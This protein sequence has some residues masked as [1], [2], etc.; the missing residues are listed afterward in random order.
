MPKK[1]G[2]RGKDAPQLDITEILTQ[3][4]KIRRNGK[5][6]IV[7]QYEL[8]LR[9]QVKK[10]LKDKSLPAIENVLREA[11]KFDLVMPPPPAP[12]NGGVLVVPNR[13]TKESWETLFEKPKTDSEAES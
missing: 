6:E 5:Q 10:A 13:L 4:V 12:D 3:P 11:R 2:T 9:A 1:N 7:S 8:Q